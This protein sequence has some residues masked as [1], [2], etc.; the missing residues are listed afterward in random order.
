[1]T[2]ID[3]QI[4]FWASLL[5]IIVKHRKYRIYCMFLAVLTANKNS[6]CLSL[7]ITSEKRTKTLQEKNLPDQVIFRWKLFMKNNPQKSI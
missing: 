5:K 4:S 3:M 2:R 7:I 1:M 6:F